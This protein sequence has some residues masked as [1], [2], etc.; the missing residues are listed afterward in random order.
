MTEY[1]EE[2]SSQLNKPLLSQLFF[3]WMQ[4]NNDIETYINAKGWFEFIQHVMQTILDDSEK[5]DLT[6]FDNYSQKLFVK[7]ISEKAAQRAIT[8]LRSEIFTFMSQQHNEKTRDKIE[9]STLKLAKIFEYLNHLFQDKNKSHTER[10]INENPKNQLMLLRIDGARFDAVTRMDRQLKEILGIPSDKLLVQLDWDKII[11]PDNL[12]EV[13]KNWL[14]V[15][16]KQLPV[17]E[18]RYRLKTAHADWLEVVEIGRI[19]YSKEKQPMGGVAVLVAQKR[20]AS[21]KIS[22]EDVFKYLLDPR[23]DYV[24]ILKAGEVESLVSPLMEN[25]LRQDGVDDDQQKVIYEQKLIKINSNEIL[26]ILVQKRFE[27]D[28]TRSNHNIIEIP[29]ISFPFKL[30]TLE[31]GFE[32]PVYLFWGDP[33]SSLA[34]KNSEIIDNL[35]KISNELLTTVEV[36]RIYQIIM[37]GLKQFIPHLDVGALLLP[38][39]KG[40]MIGLGFGF[41]RSVFQQNI[42]IPTEELKD[43]GT[44][45][46]ETKKALADKLKK[47]LFAKKESDV[48]D[49]LLDV[50]VLQKK[51]KAILYVATKAPSYQFSYDD[52]AIFRLFVLLAQAALERVTANLSFNEKEQNYRLLFERSILPKWIVQS[53]KGIAFNRAFC[54]MMEITPE[55]AAEVSIESWLIPEDRSRFLKTLEYI[56]KN[57]TVFNETFRIKRPDNQIFNAL[58]NFIPIEQNGSPA[59]LIEILELKGIAAVS[60]VVT[61]AADKNGTIAPLTEGLLHE[62]NNVFGAILPSVQLILKEPGNAENN[63]KRAK[64]IYQMTTRASELLKKVAQYS[65]PT[66]MHEKTI[67]VHGFIHDIIPL[68]KNTLGP[69]ISIFTD[70]PDHEISVRGNSKKLTEVLVNLAEKAKK[71]MPHGG[72]FLIR[73]REK[74]IPSSQ[75]YKTIKPGKYVCITLQDT[76]GGIPADLHTK[77]LQTFLKANEDSASGSLAMVQAIVKQHDGYITMQSVENKGTLFNIYLPTSQVSQ[78]QEKTQP[79]H[80][81]KKEPAKVPIVISPKRKA[82]IDPR[83]K[84]PDSSE[85]LVLVIDDEPHLLEVYETML[86]MLGYRTMTAK[87]G[88]EGIRKFFENNKKISLVILDYGMPDM[89]GEQVYYAIKKINPFAEVILSTGMGEQRKISHFVSL[90]NV[91]LLQKPFT[92]ED[93]AK[94]LSDG[95]DANQRIGYSY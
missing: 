6:Q 76:G 86:D 34:D 70:I 27:S 32:Q 4:N 62:L 26:R 57:N 75:K 14:D 82:V 78:A 64:L 37:H 39:S 3:N 85:K 13:K 56:I 65:Q 92:L 46:S 28:T 44:A 19:L 52:R 51:P 2:L 67:E 49:Q 31:H 20:D 12:L 16:N 23:K 72:K 83:M 77:L 50:V 68:L 18:F 91:R 33:E 10:T 25:K 42:I 58:L 53:G 87:N 59:V 9:N 63:L 80:Q 21:I 66:E 88:R 45:P 89:N 55:N 30:I 40:F 15:I 36:N 84:K 94:T 69:T 48:A 35:V 95:V 8:T 71:N 61:P 43:T 5:I 90:N 73:V 1:Y 79:A 60:N 93:L 74:N 81:S 29:G 7:E 47:I 41:S 24:L 11:H 17:Y 54:R 22:V 38:T